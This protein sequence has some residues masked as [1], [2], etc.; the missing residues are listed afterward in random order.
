MRKSIWI[1]IKLN[2]IRLER[3]QFNFQGEAHTPIQFYGLT[4]LYHGNIK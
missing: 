2:Y 4:K 1:N 3:V